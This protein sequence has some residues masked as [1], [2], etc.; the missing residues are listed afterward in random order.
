MPIVLTTNE[1]VLN[2]DHAWDD[3][4]GVQY[5]YPNQYKNKIRT[6]EDFVYYRGVHR[7]D[8]RRGQAEYFGRGR[9]GTIRIDPA[10]DGSSRPSWFC[11]IEDY[12][13]FDPPVPAK[14]DS[15]FYEQIQQNMWRN[16][17]RDLDPAV[18]ASI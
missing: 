1:V 18:F 3:I 9:I 13:P 11:A 4:E 7:K 8:G 17:V 10:T 2:P 6:G 15:V 14:V 12:A 5:H 16:G